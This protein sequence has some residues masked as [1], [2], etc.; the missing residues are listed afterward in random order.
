MRASILIK[1]VIA[2]AIAITIAGCST[3]PIVGQTFQNANQSSSHSRVV[4]VRRSPAGM[5]RDN[6]HAAVQPI[7]F[8]TCPAAISVEY[9]SDYKNNVINVFAGK[10][11]GQTP[12]GKITAGV[13]N[14]QGLY[15]QDSTHDLYVAN[16]GRGNVL[17]FHRGQNIAYDTYHDPT[18]Q[19]PYDVTVS[20]DGTIIASNVFQQGG[21]NTG[22]LST[23]TAGPNGGTFVGNFPMTND[24]E[25][26][27]VSVD[28][29]GTVYYNDI[30]R[31]SGIGALWSLTCPS[32]ACGTQTQVAGVSF[33]QPGG[34]G[35]DRTNDLLANNAQP[36]TAET[37]ELPNPNPKTF[38]IDNG[39]LDLAIDTS[40]R[41][42]FAL[43][44]LNS[45]AAEYSYPS[46]A[47]IGRVQCVPGCVASGIA[48]DP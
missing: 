10:F 16:T 32:G 38:P 27:W 44:S 45:D 41:H 4:N 33:S 1:D 21:P 46:G 15:V 25:G 37:F 35:I 31:T 43:D 13:T 30:D 18:G 24:S 23:W 47:L 12:C 14:P 20:N 26:L 22:S 2:A 17:V 34:L 19:F 6:T 5:H 9:F 39:S 42:W 48:V 29:H 8:Y 28:T 7:S 11:D 3:G 40:N 36:G